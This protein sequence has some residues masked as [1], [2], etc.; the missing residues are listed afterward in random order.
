VLR[1][2]HRLVV[3]PA[4]LE[5]AKVENPDHPHERWPSRGALVRFEDLHAGTT[6]A[7]VHLHYDLGVVR[8]DSGTRVVL[9]RGER[10]QHN[11]YNAWK[12]GSTIGTRSAR[13]HSLQM[14]HLCSL[15][16]RRR[17]NTENPACQ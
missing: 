8:F 2:D 4:S 17:E 9:E 15:V 6:G 10:G 16:S 1:A 13:P 7:S 5:L 14:I 12:A 3:G 11:S